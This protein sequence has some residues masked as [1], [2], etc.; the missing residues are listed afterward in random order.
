MNARSLL[1]VIEGILA[2]EL[3]SCV[4]DRGYHHNVVVPAPDLQA[5]PPSEANGRLDAATC[6]QLCVDSDR[7]SRQH[8]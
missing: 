3:A 6:A 7:R 2:L 8:V 5:H 1:R 4:V